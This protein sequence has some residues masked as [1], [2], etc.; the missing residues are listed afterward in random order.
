M[1]IVVI[2]RIRELW[3]FSKYDREVVRVFQ[4]CEHHAEIVK[5]GRY[6][7]IPY[8]SCKISA[9]VAQW[10]WRRRCLN[11]FYHISQVRVKPATGTM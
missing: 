10:F 11:S 4:I 9:K 5:L 1:K 3:I 7:G 2:L 8:A 6:G